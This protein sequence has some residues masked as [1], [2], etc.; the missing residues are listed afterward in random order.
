MST[1]D[2]SDSWLFNQPF[3][4]NMIDPATSRA[5]FKGVNE[6][7]PFY[8]RQLIEVGW[9]LYGTTQGCGRCY[10]NSRVITYPSWILD[11]SIDFREWYL[12]H[13]M[14]H[15]YNWIN[16]TE[17]NHGPVFMYFLKV[18]C[19]AYAVYHELGYKPRNAAAA[20]IG[21]LP[22]VKMSDL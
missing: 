9:N 8:A 7:L 4:P 14:A 22:K 11:K 13:E 12:A 21:R 5:V 1:P 2:N 16:G 6:I 17:D 15:A 18:I 19:P 20:G 3:K 10:Y